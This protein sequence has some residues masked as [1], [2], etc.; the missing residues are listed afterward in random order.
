MKMSRKLIVLAMAATAALTPSMPAMATSTF[1]QTCGQPGS[2]F[3]VA[4][5]GIHIKASPN[6]ANLYTIAQGRTFYTTRL[7][8][9]RQRDPA[10]L[11]RPA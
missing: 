5:T 1:G 4:L 10:R 6:G 9:F 8:W 3:T 2:R 11:P 7:S